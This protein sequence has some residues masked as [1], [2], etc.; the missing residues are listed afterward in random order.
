MCRSGD[1]VSEIVSSQQKHSAI[2]ERGAQFA[3]AIEHPSSVDR[4]E[5]GD[6][7]LRIQSHGVP[8]RRFL[9]PLDLSS[10]GAER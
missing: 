2:A 5:V 9:P 6:A 8:L 3:I 7:T 10:P 4:G 1:E